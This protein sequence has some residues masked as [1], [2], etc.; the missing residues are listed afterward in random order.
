MCGTP[1]KPLL[2]PYTKCPFDKFKVWQML[3]GVPFTMVLWP[4]IYLVLFFNLNSNLAKYSA[5]RP[6]LYMNKTK[7]QRYLITKITHSARN[8]GGGFCNRSAK[9]L[10][11]LP[12]ETNLHPY[13]FSEDQIDIGVL[14][15]LL[16][17]LYHICSFSLIGIMLHNHFYLQPTPGSP[18]HS[19]LYVSHISCSLSAPVKRRSHQFSKIWAHLCFLFFFSGN[20][21]LL[22]FWLFFFLALEKCRIL[23]LVLLSVG[24]TAIS[25]T[26]NSL[27]PPPKASSGDSVTALLNYIGWF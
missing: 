13:H 23:R 24:D 26:A 10:C 17:E 7:A 9:L 5:I 22:F 8:L 21:H 1:R 2:V 18:C 19:W 6:I 12:G 20:V 14:E 15:A 3:R 16:L 27:Q 25:S 11:T 4:A